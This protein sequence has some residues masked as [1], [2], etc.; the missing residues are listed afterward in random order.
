MIYYYYLDNKV[1]IRF[2]YKI[3]STDYKILPVYKKEVRDRLFIINTT[4][5]MLLLLLLILLIYI[6]CFS[7]SLEIYLK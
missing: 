7:T 3:L 5:I 6:I 2:L 1:Y 4:I